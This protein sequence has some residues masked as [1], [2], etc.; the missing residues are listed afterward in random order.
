MKITRHAVLAILTILLGASLP[1]APPE[2]SI[3]VI[4]APG[5]S[6]ATIAVGINNKGQVAGNW[7]DAG[8][9]FLYTPGAGAI[10]VGVLSGSGGTTGWGINDLGQVVGSSYA[11]V[12]SAVYG[13]GY[14]S[15]AFLYTPGQGI[16]DISPSSLGQ[17]DSSAYDINNS[18]TVSGATFTRE[19][20]GAQLIQ[21]GFVRSNAGSWNYLSTLSTTNG[22]PLYPAFARGINES[23]IPVG[24]SDGK[25]VKFEAYVDPLS[26]DV[27]SVTSLGTSGSYANDVND[28][29]LAAGASPSSTSSLVTATVFPGNQA[30]ISLGTLG[31][32]SQSFAFSINNADQVVGNSQTAGFTNTHAFLHTG[33]LLYDLNDLIPAGSGITDIQLAGSTLGGPDAINEW[34]QIAAYG[35]VAGLGNRALI[36]SPVHPLTSGFDL[37]IPGQAS[38]DVKFVAGMTFDQFTATTNPLA[39]SLG[40]TVN[41]LGGTAGANR[42]VVVSFGGA[43]SFGG[44]ASDVVAL[45]G[46]AGDTFVLQLSYDEALAITIFGAEANAH[47]SWLDPMDGLWKNA[48]LGNTNT[49]IVGL[50]GNQGAGA[51]DPATDFVPGYF[52]VDP[53]S[54]TV[55]AV[56]DHNSAF[57]VTAVV[58]E[59]AAVALVAWGLGM[60]ILFRKRHA[61]ARNA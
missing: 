1:A 27:H 59:P 52:G 13:T 6:G 24:K 31:T 2:Y 11:N 32:G 56:L 57:A 20:D 55:W 17:Y 42:E 45:S 44:L 37:S 46:T 61:R 43:G 16:L 53:V 26:G 25:A 58:P 14:T 49:G 51:Y 10:D 38:R 60:L 8:R 35:T 50:T 39:G 54:N 48:V 28:H 47:L 23:G 30:P 40:T 19:S 41:L 29:G 15:H 22:L 5:F 12:T 21:L 7:V 9:S 18:G 3:A 4:D 33:G 36:L 34:G